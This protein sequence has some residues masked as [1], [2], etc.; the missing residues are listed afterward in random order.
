MEALERVVAE[1]GFDKAARQLNIT[2]SAVSQRVKLLEDQTGMVLLTRTTPPVPTHEGQALLKHF[3]QV[4]QLEGDLAASLKLEG[5]SSFRT[6]ALGIN[7][8]SLATW[9]YPAVSPFLKDR[10]VVLDLRVDD[11]DQTHKL[12]RNGEVLGCISSEQTPV[13]GCKVSHLG[14]MNYRMV[15]TPEFRAQY[16]A[17]G[18]SQESL[19]AAPA[20]IYNQ[21]DDLHARYIGKAISSECM[22]DIPIHFVPSSEQFVV[23]ILDS[24]AYGMVPDLQSMPYLENGSLVELVPDTTWQVSLYW[25]RWNLDSTLLDDFS[26]AIVKNAVIC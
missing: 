17:S 23:I 4:R 26:K 13:Q 1:G 9:F 25:H 14:N 22:R 12:L 10:K 6:M 21:H 24:Q 11:Q 7:A 8:D 16:F 19:K 15:A 2:Q 18:L 5:G 20:V 3:I